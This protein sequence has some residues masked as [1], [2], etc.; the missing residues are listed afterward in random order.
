[1]PVIGLQAC[2]GA[3]AHDD[4]D[5]RILICDG[6]NCHFSESPQTRLEGRSALHRLPPELARTL[7]TSAAASLDATF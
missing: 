6:P 3:P 1:M 5:P 2:F 7:A 4:I